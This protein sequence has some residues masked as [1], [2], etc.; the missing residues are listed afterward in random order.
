MAGA[1]IN[2]KRIAD[3]GAGID[4]INIKNIDFFY[5][6]LANNFQRFRRYFVA[7][8]HINFTGLHIDQFF[9]KEIAAKLIIFDQKI[10]ETFFLKFFGQTRG[11][12]AT[13]FNH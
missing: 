1:F 6:C 8:F 7:R 9:G 5:A 3:K 11:N 12:L 4:M 10:F 2:G 13:C